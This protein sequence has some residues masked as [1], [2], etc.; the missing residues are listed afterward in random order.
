MTETTM[1][2]VHVQGPDDVMA[3]PDKEVADAV[4]VVLNAQ[5]KRHAKP[6]DPLLHA[7]VIEWPYGYE[8][9]SAEK[10]QLRFEVAPAAQGEGHG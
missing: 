4:C 7:A 2:A 8:A 5:F 10:D 3:A 1:W 9:W 6:G